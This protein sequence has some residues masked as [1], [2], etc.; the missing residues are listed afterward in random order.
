[1]GLFGKLKTALEGRPAKVAPSDPILDLDAV[2]KLVGEY[3]LLLQRSGGSISS[4]QLLPASREKIKAT[5][6]IMGKYA[7]VAG[8]NGPQVLAKMRASYASL[9]DFVA[10]A[11]AAIA[12]QYADLLKAGA[13]IDEG[14]DR[15]ERIRQLAARWANAGPALEIKERSTN[16]FTRL[17]KEFDAA[18]AHDSLPKGAPLI[19]R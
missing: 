18:V 16:E 12:S 8:G 13:S 17:L 3:G 15:D 5:L 4:E 9:A 7:K 10:P 11:D 19:H 1:M 14:S 6:V 2:Q